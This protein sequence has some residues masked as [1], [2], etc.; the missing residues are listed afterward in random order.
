MP[1]HVLNTF[2]FFGGGGTG[3]WTWAS[4]LL[5]RCFTSWPMFAAC[6]AFVVC[7]RGSHSLPGTSLRFDPSTSAS[8]I[9]KIIGVHCHVWAYFL[10]YGLAKF[11]PGLPQTE[12]LP[13]SSWEYR[14]AL[15][16][17]LTSKHFC[18][19]T[20]LFCTITNIFF[21]CYRWSNSCLSRALCAKNEYLNVKIMETPREILSMI[22]LIFLKALIATLWYLLTIS[23]QCLF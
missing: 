18:M 17:C 19:K 21:I 4:Y 8:H 16:L 22:T 5:G 12:T 10:R 7:Q 2:F 14:H 1:R 20:H 6:F 9:T 13:L 15:L 3:V 23:R 11:S